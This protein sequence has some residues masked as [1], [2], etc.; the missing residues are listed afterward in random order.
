M[1]VGLDGGAGV[2][3]DI[4]SCHLAAAV[5]VLRPPGAGADAD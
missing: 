5:G 3:L 1:L 2:V 4:S